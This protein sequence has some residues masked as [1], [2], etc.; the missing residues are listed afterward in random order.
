M[1]RKVVKYSLMLIIVFILFNIYVTFEYCCSTPRDICSNIGSVK[2][3]YGY[4]NYDIF[5]REHIGEK[6]TVNYS[7]LKDYLLEY[8]RKCKEFNKAEEKI[9]DRNYK[10]VL[11]EFKA[12]NSKNRSP[13]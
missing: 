2:T 5:Q 12:E 4:L 8:N 11:E 6:D 3:Y 10:Q 7:I 9:I 13:K 1:I